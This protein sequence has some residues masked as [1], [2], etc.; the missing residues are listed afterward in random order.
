MISPASVCI[1]CVSKNDTALACYN[2][3]VHQPIQL[4]FG[5]SV[6]KKA[7]SQIVLYF[8]T[9]PNYCCCTTWGNRKPKIVSFHL[10][11][12]SCFASRHRKH[13]HIITWSQLNRSSFSQES[14][15]C[16]KQNRIVCHRLLLH[17]HCLPSL[18]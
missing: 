9:S 5:R 17:T 6:A 4:I 3:D 2:F 16:T 15:V 8:S 18:S 14:A 13:I 1:Q 12:Q 10:N 11:A 7:S